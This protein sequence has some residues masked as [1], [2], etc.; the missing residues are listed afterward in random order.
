MFTQMD[1]PFVFTTLAGASE[2]TTAV[3]DPRTCGGAFAS[4]V[5]FY[6]TFSGGSNVQS[7]VGGANS[8]VGTETTATHAYPID[9]RNGFLC[10]LQQRPS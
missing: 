3:T 6:S 2:S 7:L 5:I 9:V 4:G 1:Q 10:K 8:P